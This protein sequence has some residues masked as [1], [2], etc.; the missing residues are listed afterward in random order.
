MSNWVQ[1]VN[2]E[3]SVSNPQCTIIVIDLKSTGYRKTLKK[4]LLDL[5]FKD[6]RSYRQK[7]CI[8]ILFQ[9]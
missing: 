4:S 9:L 7:S 3:I 8:I 5:Q 2:V 6:D 1:L